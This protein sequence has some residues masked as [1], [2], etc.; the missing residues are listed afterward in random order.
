MLKMQKNVIATWSPIWDT[1]SRNSE[2]LMTN[3]EQDMMML[4][5][6]GRTLRKPAKGVNIDAGFTN[7]ENS[8]CEA[9]PG[10]I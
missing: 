10:E 8:V 1:V 2:K 6:T 3:P 5:F 9:E 7:T 4:L